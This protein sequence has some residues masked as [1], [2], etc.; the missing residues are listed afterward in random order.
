MAESAAPW[1]LLSGCACWLAPAP[2]A[3]YHSHPDEFDHISLISGSPA[4]AEY[5]ELLKSQEMRAGAHLFFVAHDNMHN[6]D[7]EEMRGL[8]RSQA[9]RY[10]FN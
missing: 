9:C 5:A 8:F 2:V 1:A 10:C 4:E 3:F 6:N 7:G